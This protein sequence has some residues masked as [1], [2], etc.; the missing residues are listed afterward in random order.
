[1]GGGRNQTLNLE[2]AYARAVSI[3][4]RALTDSYHFGQ[5]IAYDFGRPFERGTNA[6]AGGS[7]SGA[8]GPLVFYV[9]AEYQHAPAA[10]APSDAMRAVMAESDG[11]P[12]AVAPGAVAPEVVPSVVPGIDRLELLDAYAAVNLHNWQL[13]LGRQSLSW[14]PGSDS[15]LWSDNIRPLNMVRL[16]NPEPFTLPGLL[17]YLGPVRIDQFFGRLDGHPYIRRPFEYGQKINV[18]PFSFLELGF[19]RAVT[20]GGTGTGS[21]CSVQR[22]CADPLTAGNLL[23]SYAGIATGGTA[24]AVGSVPGDNHAE[25]DWTFYVPKVRHYVVLY[26]DAYADDDIV[27]IENPARNPWHPGIYLTRIPGLPKLE[28]H[29][30]GESPEQAGLIAAAGGGNHGQFNY[31]NQSYPDGYTNGG[32]L[33][34]NAVGRDG[35]TI[36]CWLTYA[37][38]ARQTV[39]VSYKHNSIA[40]DFIPGGAAW[41]DYS[42]RDEIYFR[43]GFYAKAEVQYENISHYPALFHGPQT[44]VTAVVEVGFYP[45]KNVRGQGNT[46]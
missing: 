40:A 34:G 24:A 25:M 33:I 38:S 27:P 23:D 8:A 35:R 11:V 19:G 30:E 29:M 26:G 6:Q 28:F 31:W 9:R 18:K 44:N 45:R 41:Q 1:L 42:L 37:V 22:I 21:V 12:L 17:R 10:P 43:S 2:S 4:G 14:A 32:N 7:F 20:I 3:N 13:I 16:V 46:P 39:Q 15:M 5:T 36:Q